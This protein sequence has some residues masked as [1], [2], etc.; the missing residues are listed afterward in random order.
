LKCF[1]L[2]RTVTSSE[3]LNIVSLNDR[4][5]RGRDSGFIFLPKTNLPCSYIGPV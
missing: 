2:S 3:A 1:E 5:I 4:F